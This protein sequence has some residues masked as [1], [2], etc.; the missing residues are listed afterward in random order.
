M[1]R[2][3]DEDVKE[4]TVP[5][6][7]EG[8]VVVRV[9][10]VCH[11]SP[12]AP[13]LPVPPLP[14]PVEQGV[15]VAKAVVEVGE[16]ESSEEEEADITVSVAAVSAAVTELDVLPPLLTLPVDAL[17]VGTVRKSK[18]TGSDADLALP[19]SRSLSLPDTL[20]VSLPLSRLLL[21]SLPC[22]GNGGGGETP[23]IGNIV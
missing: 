20:S 3:R 21:L 18:L 10:C 14:V 4:D 13:P 1:E 23:L 19:L 17:T 9:L 16:G 22:G 15:E 11:T 7:D 12:T 5:P 8:P 2:E 6:T